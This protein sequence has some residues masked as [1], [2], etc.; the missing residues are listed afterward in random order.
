MQVREY[1]ERQWAKILGGR[2]SVQDFIFAKEVRCVR[3]WGGAGK[4]PVTRTAT[5]CSCAGEKPG[6]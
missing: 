3:G 5:T 6:P 2:V 1:L 4:G